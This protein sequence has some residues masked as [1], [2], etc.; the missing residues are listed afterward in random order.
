MRTKHGSLP[1]EYMECFEQLNK[2]A[3]A[4]KLNYMLVGAT[5][6]DLVME[7]VY[8]IESPRK[9]YDI[10]ISI[11]V[12]S[13]DAF[14]EFK[15]R[16]SES[17]FEADPRIAQRMIY[18]PSSGIR[19]KLD[20][21]PFGGVSDANGDLSWP[22]KGDFKMSVLGFDEA[23]NTKLIIQTEND[24]EIPAISPEGF[25]LL[26]L[27][28]WLD[29]PSNI[30]KKDAQDIHFILSN[31]E[32]LDNNQHAIY[33]EGFAE[34]FDFDPDKAT[35]AKLGFE[36]KRLCSEKTLG[37]LINKLFTDKEEI[38][39]EELAREMSNQNERNFDLL[40]ALKTSFLMD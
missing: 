11:F 34:R 9:T 8:G 38:L 15:A 19:V 37:Y 7:Y 17:N 14:E 27:I 24:I 18:T 26:K 21:V 5:A 20:L 32:R 2:A 40:I 22:P 39:L 10:D 25:C 1:L 23:F 4:T 6:R 30:R 12:D 36:I 28:A 31:Y 35:A 13:W 29:R 16:L 33:D 3:K